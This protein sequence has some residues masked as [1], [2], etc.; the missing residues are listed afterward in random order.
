MPIKNAEHLIGLGTR[1]QKDPKRNQ[2]IR[3]INKICFFVILVITPY[4]LL[5]LYFRST[6]ATLVQLGAI[7]ALDLT[8]LLNARQFFNLVRALTLLIG[9]FHIFNMV[10]IL[11]LE[12]GIHFYFSAYRDLRRSRYYR[13]QTDGKWLATC[14]RGC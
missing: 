9:N 12:S 11:G 14:Q 13:T 8:V 7:L 6:L 5:T 3:L 2:I 10:L 4:M 1:F